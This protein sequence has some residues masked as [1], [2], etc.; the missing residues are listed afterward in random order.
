MQNPSINWE[1]KRE[2]LKARR[3]P[4]FNHYLNNPNHC[5]LALEIKNID[6][7]IADCTQRMVVKKPKE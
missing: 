1:S 2:E 5:H 7:Q 3:N 4:L 6:D